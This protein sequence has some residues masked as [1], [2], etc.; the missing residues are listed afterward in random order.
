MR[1]KL[2]P[3]HVEPTYAEITERDNS[4]RSTFSLQCLISTKRAE[5]DNRDAET[6]YCRD[7]IATN[8]GI[9]KALQTEVAVFESLVESRR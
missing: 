3:Q 5:I 8:Q 2:V 6:A 4:H 9:V 7:T 1:V